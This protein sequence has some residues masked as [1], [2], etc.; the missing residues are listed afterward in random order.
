MAVQRRKSPF[1][2]LGEFTVKQVQ[3]D[4]LSQSHKDILDLFRRK[5]DTETEFGMGV[6]VIE[7]LENE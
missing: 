4:L 1:V 6:L 3:D 2:Q 5:R 7:D